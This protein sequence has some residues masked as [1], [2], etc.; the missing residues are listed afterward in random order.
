MD[1]NPILNENFHESYVFEYFIA[2]KRERKKKFFSISYNES[3]EKK[4][5]HYHFSSFNYKSKYS[6][7]Y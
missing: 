7:L 3:I 1:I 2:C 5:Y 6:L 4:K